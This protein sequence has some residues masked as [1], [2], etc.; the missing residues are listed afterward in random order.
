MEINISNSEYIVLMFFYIRH[1]S[2][3]FVM[4]L[5]WRIEFI[6]PLFKFKYKQKHSENSC[7]PLIVALKIHVFALA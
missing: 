1:P 5:K 4:N 6:S 2:L 3:E 7:L